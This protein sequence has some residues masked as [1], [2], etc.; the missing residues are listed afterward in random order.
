MNRGLA[1]RTGGPRSGV[2]QTLA[3]QRV[4]G[5]AP[6]GKTT[7][8]SG[9]LGDEIV[10]YVLARIPDRRMHEEQCKHHKAALTAYIAKSAADALPG[11]KDLAKL[12][13][14]KLSRRARLCVTPQPPHLV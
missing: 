9:H 6:L 3:S 4:S 1:Q 12:I 11:H 14:M 7:G 5:F 10:F 8:V 13:S 2:A